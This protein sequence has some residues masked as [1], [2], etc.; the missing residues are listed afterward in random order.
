MNMTNFTVY[1]CPKCGR[2]LINAV[3]K[4]NEDTGEWICDKCWAWAHHYKCDTCGRTS[5]SG[6]PVYYRNL[7]K[8]A[9]VCNN[10]WQDEPVH[11]KE[12]RKK[13]THVFLQ[14]GGFIVM[15]YFAGPVIGMLA[16]ILFYLMK[17]DIEKKEEKA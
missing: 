7:P 6:N 11:K 12:M 1:R 17:R 8:G 9:Y 10:C 13:L 5:A 3:V 4:R 14:V 15:F 16:L 2:H